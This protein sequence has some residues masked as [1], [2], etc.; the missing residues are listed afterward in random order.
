MAT[1]NYSCITTKF[2]RDHN[3]SA[4]STVENYHPGL[5]S[6]LT[7]PLFILSLYMQLYF[8]VIRI[9]IIHIGRT[10]TE[11]LLKFTCTV[12][13]TV[14]V[15]THAVQCRRVPV[16][17]KLVRYHPVTSQIDQQ[18]AVQPK[19]WY[20]TTRPLRSTNRLQSSPVPVPMYQFVPV[21]RYRYWFFSLFFS[22]TGTYTLSCAAPPD[23]PAPPRRA[24]PPHFFV[25]FSMHWI[26]CAI[27]FARVTA[28]GGFIWILL[29]S[30][31]FK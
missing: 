22:L 8:S 21:D 9:I 17:E 19:N 14:H 20:G 7:W 2:T 11:V 24:E 30:Y 1:C 13:C 4:L 3:I 27:V 29:N 12:R 26:V 15:Q 25:S 28:T 16:H 18:S 6:A 10:N 31:V 23:R 5:L